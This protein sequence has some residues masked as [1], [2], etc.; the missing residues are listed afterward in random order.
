MTTASPP[1]SPPW[2]RRV[3]TMGAVVLG[4]VLLVAAYAKLIHPEGFVEQIAAEKLDLLFSARAVAFLALALEVA[5]GLALVSGIRRLW[6]LIP[7]SLLVAFFLFLT[8]RSWYREAHGLSTADGSCGCFGNLVERTPKEAF[9]QDLALLVPAL[10]LA[11]FGRGG[12]QPFPRW[13]AACIAL[14]T[15]AS[16]AFAWKAPDLPLDDLATRLKPGVRVADICTG[17][18]SERV[19]LDFVLPEALKGEHAVVMMDLTSEKAA[20]AVPA[21]NAYATGASGPSLWA[22]SAAEGE[23]MHRFYWERG[24]LFEIREAPPSL[25]KPLYRRLPRSFLVRDGL[26]VETYSSLPPLAR[27]AG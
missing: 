7:A 4:L 26:V 16:L 19:C 9:F 2:S 5:L 18:G 24:P 3:G 13:R 11:F 21:L 8:G 25:L 14:A 10:G 17:Q 20:A 1:L 6:V 27:L 22:L 12:R 23:Q 15:M